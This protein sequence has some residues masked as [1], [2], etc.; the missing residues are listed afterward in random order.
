MILVAF[1]IGMILCGAVLAI[2]HAERSEG[3]DDKFGS[4][5]AMFAGWAAFGMLI[6]GGTYA[7]G[8]L[9]PGALAAA[10]LVL[11]TSK[12]GQVLSPLAPMK[13]PLSIGALIASL[14]TW[15]GVLNLMEDIPNV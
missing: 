5:V 7:L 10:V 3:V 15:I 8:L 1:I 14:L 13:L 9:I 2:L 6:M 4:A 12:F 11:R